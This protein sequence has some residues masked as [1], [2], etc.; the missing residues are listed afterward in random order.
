MHRRGTF[1]KRSKIVTGRRPFAKDVSLRNYDV[2]S[3]DEWEDED[4]GEDIGDSGEEDEGSE[5]NEPDE[6]VFDEFFRHDDDFGSDAENENMGGAPTSTIKR[7]TS[8]VK[9]SAGPRFI[10]TAP[11]LHQTPGGAAASS[12]EIAPSAHRVNADG[13]MVV[14][15]E[16]EKDVLKL[17]PFF[18]VVYPPPSAAESSAPASSIASVS[19]GATAASSQSPVASSID[20]PDEAPA[21]E[22]S[23][24]APNEKAVARK[25]SD[26]EVITI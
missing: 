20:G 4:V 15:D 5:A 9:S 13:L 1:S 24:S 21:A 12:S 8:V 19:T 17:L 7:P 25:M 11:V 2:D 26:V 6:L 23:A 3:A 10:N 18:A 14:C 22:G 16:S